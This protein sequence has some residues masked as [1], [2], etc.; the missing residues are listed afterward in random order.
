MFSRYHG[1]LSMSPDPGEIPGPLRIN[2]RLQVV[3]KERERESQN[4]AHNLTSNTKSKDL[5]GENGFA[6]N[7]TNKQHT[8]ERS[9]HKGSLFLNDPYNSNANAKKKKR[10]SHFQN[11][12]KQS[13]N[14]KQPSSK[15]TY[16]TSSR[17]PKSAS[18]SS[19]PPKSAAN[20]VPSSQS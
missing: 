8:P 16:T 20:P 15:R 17:P 4:T 18:Q 2:L 14:I 1:Y 3:A 19:P 7:A 11:K 10:S 13:S 9:K 5:E 12:T 6:N